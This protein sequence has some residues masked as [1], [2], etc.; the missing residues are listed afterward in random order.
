MFLLVSAFWA[1]FYQH[2]STWILQ[3][4]MMDLN[5]WGGLKILPS[6]VQAIGRQ[7]AYLQP[8]VIT[9]NEIPRSNTWQ[10]ANF[11]VAYLP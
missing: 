9:F 4:L 8:D 6:Q 11:V 10:M 5:L 3:A 7:V 1:L 2:G